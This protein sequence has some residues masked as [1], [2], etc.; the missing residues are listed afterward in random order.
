MGVRN[1]S[2][3]K[4]VMMFPPV[5]FRRVSLSSGAIAASA[6][7][8]SICGVGFVNA[9]DAVTAV[10]EMPEPR[11]GAIAHEK[12]RNAFE[13]SAWDSTMIGMPCVK[14]ATRAVDCSPATV[15]PSALRTPA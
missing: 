3:I 6:F 11:H 9:G 2:Q 1:A 13:S 14:T 12:S 7:R 10:A 15:A 5:P 4:Q 8:L